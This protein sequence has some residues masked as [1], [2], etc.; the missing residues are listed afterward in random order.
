VEIETWLEA[1]AEGGWAV[2]LDSIE[3]GL[4]AKVLKIMFENS[5][6]KLAFIEAFRQRHR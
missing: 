6:D 5:S 1:N 4:S 3:E 2:G